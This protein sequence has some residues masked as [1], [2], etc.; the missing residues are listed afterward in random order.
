M[1]DATIGVEDTPAD[2]APQSII[3]LTGKTWLASSSAFFSLPSFCPSQQVP[4]AILEGGIHDH[5]FAVQ[6]QPAAS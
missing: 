1:K 3:R 2:H 6:P 5:I 4:D